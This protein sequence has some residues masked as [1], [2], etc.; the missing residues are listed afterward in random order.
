[1]F[2]CFFERNILY[3]LV[4]LTA[5]TEDSPKIVERFGTLL[6]A[7]LVAVSGMKCFR[8]SYS[9]L[10]SQ[11]LILTFT[12]LFFKYDF[13]I[14]QESFLIDYAIMSVIYY[15][16]FELLLK[17]MIVVALLFPSSMYMFFFFFVFR[18][19]LW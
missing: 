1:M 8:G 6:G 5:L 12:A 11:Y 10:S 2:L 4:F 9:D 16:T 17:V 18:F 14:I 3:P 7:L 15:K 19:S 13:K